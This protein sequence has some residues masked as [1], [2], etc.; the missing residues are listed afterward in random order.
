MEGNRGNTSPYRPFLLGTEERGVPSEG[1]QSVDEAPHLR[2][3]R[4]E[5]GSYIEYP[6]KLGELR[7]TTPH[8]LALKKA[9]GDTVYVLQFRTP[10]SADA[11]PGEWKRKVAGNLLWMINVP[12]D[13]E[14]RGYV[15]ALRAYT[16]DSDLRTFYF[17]DKGQADFFIGKMNGGDLGPDLSDVL[18]QRDHLRKLLGK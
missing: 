7:L 10:F 9:L 15:P 11:V 16:T 2:G 13:D 5:A 12:G 3:L 14:L 17:K 18:E 8:A 4:P 6:A 1:T